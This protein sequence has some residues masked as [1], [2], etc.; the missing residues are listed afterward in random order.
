MEFCSVDSVFETDCNTKFGSKI[1][2]VQYSKVAMRRIIVKKMW[3]LLRENLLLYLVRKKTE[4]K[5]F[6][7]SVTYC[8]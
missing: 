6:R 8:F 7:K 5:D 3:N 1:L 4:F 2:V